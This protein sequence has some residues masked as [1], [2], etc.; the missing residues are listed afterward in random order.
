MEMGIRLS[1]KL[2]TPNCPWPLDPQ[3][4]IFPDPQHGQALAVVADI[5]AMASTPPGES[6]RDCTGSRAHGSDGCAV[7]FTAQI[8]KFGQYYVEVF[9]S[10]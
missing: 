10:G 3:A 4:K 2:P 6:Y 5:E 1:L 8:S 7:Y 9:V